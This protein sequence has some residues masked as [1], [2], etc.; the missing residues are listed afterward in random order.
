MARAAH[1]AEAD[2]DV[3]VEC[4]YCHNTFSVDQRPDSQT[5]ETGQDDPDNEQDNGAEVGDYD[6]R[7]PIDR[8]NALSR[9]LL[10]AT[11]KGS[12]QR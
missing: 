6:N 5:S 11:N 8:L 12:S 2:N 7:R 3:E 4:P 1:K 10:Q 9:S